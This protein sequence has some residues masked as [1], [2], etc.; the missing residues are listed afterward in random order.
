M[1]SISHIHSESGVAVAVTIVIIAVIGCCIGVYCEDLKTK[2]YDVCI[3]YNF[4]V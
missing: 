2:P 3:H 4:V 1:L